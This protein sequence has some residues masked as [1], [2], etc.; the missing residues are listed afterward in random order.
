MIIN[1]C[2]EAI[3]EKD[4]HQKYLK[5]ARQKQVDFTKLIDSIS[6]NNKENLDWWMSL[7][8]SRNPFISNLFHNY[9]CIYLIQL[10]IKEKYFISK[11]IV[12]SPSMKKI[13]LKMINNKK[14][15]I[16]NKNNIIFF[17]IKNYT[18]FFLHLIN[19]LIKR[20]IQLIICFLSKQ[21]NNNLLNQPIT[22]I[23][24]FGLPNYYL[25]DRYYSGLLENI[26][27]KN[28]KNIFFLPTIVMTN[29][30]NLFSTYK[31]YRSNKKNFIIKEDYIKI[32]DIIYSI[33]YII[34]VR[35]IRV[36]TKYSNK[37]NIDLLVNEELK[38]T[39]GVDLSIE[40]LINYRF[41]KRLYKRNVK[42]NL[43]ID[44]WENHALDK[45][46]H[47]SL[48]NYYPK[49]KVLGYLGLFPRSLELKL[50]PSIIEQKYHFT[51]K[52]IAVIGKSIM[53]DLKIFNKNQKLLVAPSFRFNHVWSSKNFIQKNKKNNI[54][55]VMPFILD[56]CI[57][58]I[59]NLLELNTSNPRYFKN[60]FVKFHPLVSYS[61]IKSKSKIFLPSNFKIMFEDTSKCLQNSK[62]VITGMSSVSIE[63][64]A[65]GIPVILIK[66]NYGLDYDP[67]SNKVPK[68]MYKKCNNKNQIAQ[69]IET[70]YINNDI[71]LK[72]KK[73]CRNYMLNNFFTKCNK[74]TV[75]NFINQ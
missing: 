34:R 47:K 45:G 22:I 72:N 5:I 3:L 69:A 33:F 27:L 7:P 70:L 42:I 60:T 64:L 59:K 12:D 38:S 43:F 15:I 73:D 68:L 55:I 20:F 75:S 48:Y 71:N 30:F 50:F 39:K 44:W 35:F 17:T 1:L 32:P 41:I 62:L 57:Y 66:R 56:E 23:D 31:N 28:R 49:T 8:A 4:I 26:N 9:C 40:G 74:K 58:I 52:K 53:K 65:I 25:K 54:L 13:L 14:I 21:N 24:T 61:L 37:F 2:N 19:Q 10:L 36:K 63:S 51:P 46:F 29:Y 6:K 11:I 16:K 67:I 18:L